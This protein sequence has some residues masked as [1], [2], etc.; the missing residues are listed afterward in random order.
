MG[1]FPSNSTGTKIRNA[2]TG[3]YYN[4]YVGTKDEERFFRVIDSSGKKNSGINVPNK[5]FF[6]NK[7][8]YLN[9]I[10]PNELEEP[11]TNEELDI[12]E[13]PEY[14]NVNEEIYNSEEEAL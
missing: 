10:K 13:N 12:T 1:Y 11:D 7:E 4:C 14:I 5:L 8:Q 9:S 2:A 3:V 6:D